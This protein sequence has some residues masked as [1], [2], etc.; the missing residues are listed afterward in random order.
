MN[1]TRE[2]NTE[3]VIAFYDLFIQCQTRETMALYDWRV[4][5]PAQ[6]AHGERQAGLHQL[7]RAHGWPA[8]GGGVHGPARGPA[9]DQPGKTN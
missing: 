2:R 4:A 6:P 8:V 1:S 5:H 9:R 3:T 7:V